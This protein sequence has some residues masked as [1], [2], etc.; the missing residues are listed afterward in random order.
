MKFY[1]VDNK[2]RNAKSH[3]LLAKDEEDAM[4]IA[5]S[6]PGKPENL[7]ELETE[8]NI[9]KLISEGKSGLL[10]KKIQAMSFAD[11]F[12]NNKPEQPKEPWFIYKEV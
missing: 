7:V 5:S 6:Q 1:H 8:D 11:I 4:R 12:A 9:E 3:W 10:A 2:G